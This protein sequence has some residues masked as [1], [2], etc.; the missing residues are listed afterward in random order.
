MRVDEVNVN[1]KTMASSGI[2]RTHWS[3]AVGSGGSGR[4]IVRAI[5]DMY[6]IGVPLAIQ[7]PI[8]VP[9]F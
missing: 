9:S 5:V 8:R 2:L 1:M 6:P 3:L 7:V 4:A